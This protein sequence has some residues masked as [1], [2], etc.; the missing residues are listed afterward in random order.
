MSDY[1]CHVKII[2]HSDFTLQLD[3]ESKDKYG[4][5]WSTH[6]QNTIGTDQ[7][8]R[9][10]VLGPNTTAQGAGGYV[11]YTVEQNDTVLEFD[12]SNPKIG[13]NK[14]SFQANG[15][16]LSFRTK[17]GDGSWSADGVVQQGPGAFYVEYTLS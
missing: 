14:A 3:S 5:S 6:P 13:R 11:S 2:N 16:N 15:V 4:Q 10:A 8:S 17:V 9:W 12:F 7:Q 1:T